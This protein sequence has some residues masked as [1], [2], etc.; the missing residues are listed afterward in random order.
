M[1][2]NRPAFLLTGSLMVLVMLISLGAFLLLLNGFVDEIA[3]TI[4]DVMTD[5][6]TLYYY[7]EFGEKITDLD[8]FIRSE[9][10]AELQQLYDELEELYRRLDITE[11]GI[12]DEVDQLNVR[13]FYLEQEIEE[14][15]THL[16]EL[17]SQKNIRLEFYWMFA[18]PALAIS[19]IFIMFA[20]ASYY[21]EKGFSIFSE[22]CL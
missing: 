9:V 4:P 2:H 6:P 20:S 5:V 19:F 16:T 15:E 12:Y 8:G 11:E 1:T 18:Y 22:A 7:D 10:E 14:L 3:P 17:N 21:F 13:I